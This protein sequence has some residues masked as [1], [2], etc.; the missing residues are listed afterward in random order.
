[1]LAQR[2]RLAM[3]AP[4]AGLSTPRGCLCMRRPKSWAVAARTSGSRLTLPGRDG[5]S[6]E[7]ACAD[8]VSPLAREASA[9]VTPRPAPKNIRLSDGMKLS[10]SRGRDACPQSCGVA[11][12]QTM[13]AAPDGHSRKPGGSRLH[14]L[15]LMVCGCRWC[16]SVNE[17][18]VAEP[19]AAVPLRVAFFD[20]RF[21]WNYVISVGSSG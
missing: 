5:L 18:G 8:V 6:G 13:A 11:R 14:R 1:T 15:L 9:A 3:S 19:A 2:I 12:H 7:T 20:G 16:V 17:A 4:D 21:R 10:L